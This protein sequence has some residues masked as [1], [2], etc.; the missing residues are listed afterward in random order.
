MLVAAVVHV[1]QHVLA[2][3]GEVDHVGVHGLHVPVDPGPELLG[4]LQHLLAHLLKVLP[5]VLE[6]IVLEERVP[7]GH[8][9]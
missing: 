8:G 2:V 4:A 5:G 9:Y 1:G 7:E 6:E 3:V